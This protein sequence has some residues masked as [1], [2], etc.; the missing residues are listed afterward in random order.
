[1]ASSATLQPGESGYVEV[2]FNRPMMGMRD[3]LIRVPS[4]DKAKPEQTLT[5]RFEVVE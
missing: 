2:T 4:N 3:L 5:P 1:M